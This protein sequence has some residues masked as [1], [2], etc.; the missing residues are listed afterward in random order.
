MRQG[1][2]RCAEWIAAG[3]LAAAFVMAGFL[4]LR[5][6]EAF[7]QSIGKFRVFRAEWGLVLAVVLPPF[8]ILCGALLLVPRMRRPATLGIVL[9]NVAFIAM[10]AQAWARG[11]RIEC[12]CFGKWDPLAYRPGWAI[13][14]DGVFLALASWLYL[15]ELARSSPTND[16]SQ[17]RTAARELEVSA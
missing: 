16:S 13:A 4:K 14:R 11:I 5:D 9:L 10:L 1:R 17:P 2:A 7:A 15:R 3:L 8:E 12:G 6:P